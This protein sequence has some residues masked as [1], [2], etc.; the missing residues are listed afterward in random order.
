LGIILPKI[1][2]VIPNNNAPIHERI[3]HIHIAVADF[4]PL[5]SFIFLL[6]WTPT[7]ELRLCL[8]AKAI[9][10]MGCDNAAPDSLARTHRA[11]FSPLNSR[12]DDATRIE[13]DHARSST[14]VSF[15]HTAAIQPQPWGRAKGCTCNFRATF[16]ENKPWKSHHVVRN[17]RRFILEDSSNFSQSVDKIIGI[18]MWMLIY[19]DVTLPWSV[20]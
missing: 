4:S 12:C 8:R 3:K 18:K 20:T 2:Y 1:R 14:Y 13:C 6:V 19:N 5:P 11:M 9:L 10:C 17:A 15:D 16:Q 7:S